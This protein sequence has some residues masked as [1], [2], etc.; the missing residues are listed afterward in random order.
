MDQ[1]K[2][3]PGRE[4]SIKGHPHHS[5]F[6][7]WSKIMELGAL[8]VIVM[9]VFNLDLEF[10]HAPFAVVYCEGQVV[11]TVFHNLSKT[12]TKRKRYQ[13]ILDQFHCEVVLKSNSV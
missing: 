9:D 8:P 5:H 4:L 10:F 6:S 13:E 1:V 12:K 2:N 7:S 3:Y 11:R